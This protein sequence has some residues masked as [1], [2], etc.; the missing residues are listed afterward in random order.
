MAPLPEGAEEPSPPA[1][2]SGAVSGA[3]FPGAALAWLRYDRSRGLRAAV[4]AVVLLAAV[5]A[6]PSTV[7]LPAALLIVPLLRRA[8]ISGRGLLSQRRSDGD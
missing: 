5:L 4:G 1:G 3:L 6:K 7:V 8:P 2:R